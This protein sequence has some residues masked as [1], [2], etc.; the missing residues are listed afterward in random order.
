MDKWTDL[1]SRI[2]RFG[3]MAMLAPAGKHLGHTE[4][5]MPETAGLSGSAPF[6]E[7]VRGAADEC[8]CTEGTKTVLAALILIAKCPHESG[9]GAEGKD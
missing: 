6:E 3:P 8:R 1:N 7:I 4:N 9:D 5:T 2:K